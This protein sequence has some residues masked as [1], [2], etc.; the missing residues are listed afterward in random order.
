MLDELK[1]KLRK[2][3]DKLKG[4]AVIDQKVVREVLKEIQKGL[5]LSDVNVKIVFEMTKRIEEKA[6]S[7]EPPRGITIREHIIK[8]IYDEFTQ[9]LGGSTP[10]LKIKKGLNKILLVG[11]QGSGKTTT[12]AK[13]AKYFRD[14]NYKVGVFSTDTYR[15]AARL[16]LKQLI[17]G[18][19]IE[20]FD[21]KTENSVELA[22]KGIEY[23]SKRDIDIVI[24]DTAGR[25]K[26]EES[27]MK[28]MK[29][30][31]MIIKP[32]IIFLVIDASI[33]QQAYSQ[34]KAF[35]EATQIGG[36]I[37]TKLDGTAKGGG[38]LSAAAATGAKIYF[39]GTG[40]KIED[41]EE[42][43]PPRFVGRLLGLGDLETLLQKFKAIEIDKEKR[44]RLLQI[45]KGK[46]T[47][48][49][50]VEQM[51]E[52]R[53]V[54]SFSKLLDLIPGF[55]LKIPKEMLEE[56]EEKVAKWRHALDSMTDEEKI[57]PTL[58]KGS[59]IKRI[60]RGSGVDEKTIKEMIKQY[61]MSKKLLRSRKSKKF[62]K[63]F[64]KMMAKRG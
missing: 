27:L 14:S 29:Q 13:L 46:F 3:I 64:D 51:E 15:P 44:E 48:V 5:L 47:L 2:A 54:G 26:D 12:A 21:I 56:A 11:I 23:F 16:Q 1:G 17:S 20:F 8:I 52:I 30:L 60:S 31:S 35:N 38:A 59:R 24:I 55:N 53:K 19:N 9:L 33:G 45:A 58:I 61:H 7:T 37:I 22:T 40:E 28:E 57:D 41:F 49:D 4:K 18:L 34:A 25:H 10:E 6:L 63:M 32:D 36:I 43:N 62:L 42:Y 50:L 39:I